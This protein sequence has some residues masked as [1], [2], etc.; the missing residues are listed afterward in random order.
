MSLTRLLIMPRLL[1]MIALLSLLSARLMAAEST[2]ILV[3]PE[4]VS[5]F[6]DYKGSR[7]VA[8]IRDYRFSEEYSSQHQDPFINLEVVELVLLVQALQL[9]G[10]KGEI[11]IRPASTYNI[12]NKV[13]KGEVLLGGVSIWRER[14][15]SRAKTLWV[16]DPIIRQGEF[17]LGLYSCGLPVPVL[18]IEALQQ[19][20]LSSHSSW[21][22]VTELLHSLEL[23]D[24]SLSSDWG[25]VAQHSC[26]GISD[27]VAAPFTTSSGL[28]LRYLEQ[29]LTPVPGVKLRVSGTRHFIISR[30]HPK[31]KRTYFSLQR[32]LR[33]LR[34]KGN[35]A[36]ALRQSGFLH[37]A[38]NDWTFLN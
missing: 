24:L 13:E 18:D 4:V 36:R 28:P 2:I 29:L 35:I 8:D 15:A 30:L 17:Q 20:R 3:P 1:A 32:G 34:V 31:G 38:A 10:V 27:L 14:T 12:M 6:R 16:S 21:P 25:M 22:M 7:E 26:N 5:S 33:K 11:K 37:Q 23:A 19:Y 9:G